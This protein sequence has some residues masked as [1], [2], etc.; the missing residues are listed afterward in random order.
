MG[1]GGFRALQN[2]LAGGLFK[3]L[4]AV[5]LFAVFLGAWAQPAVQRAA[6]G[7]ELS[8]PGRSSG[9]LDGGVYHSVALRADGTV[10]GWGF[11]V[12]GQVGDGTTTDRATPVQVVDLEEIRRVAAGGYHS[13]ALRSDETVWAWGHNGS[14][15]LGDGTTTNSSVPVAVSGL[16]GVQ[17]VAGGSHHSLALGSDGSL[18]AWGANGAGQLGD[19]T[20]EDSSSPVEVNDLSDVTAIAAGGLS[21]FAGHNLALSVDGTVW[22]WGHNNRGQLGDGSTTNRSSPV[23]VTG[24][25]D[26]VAVAADGA[27][28]YALKSDGTVW[29]WGDNSA[30]QLGNADAGRRST[31]PVRVAI[32]D[33]VAV[34][35]GG[36]HGL[37]IRSDG[38]AWAWGKNDEGQLGDGDGG[39]RNSTSAT[40]V[41]VRDLADVTVLAAG[42]AHSLAAVDDGSAWAWG[43]NSVGQLGDGTTTRRLTPV[44]IANLTGIRPPET[45]SIPPTVELT[46]PAIGVTVFHTTV[47]TA[48]ADDNV[49]VDRVELLIDG[50]MVASD[51]EEPYE[52]AWDTTE[53]SD[54]DRLV[55]VRA[56]DGAGLMATDGI[57]VIVANDATTQQ[58]L[59]SDFESGA[60]SVD[61]YVR[62]A[63]W[64]MTGNHDELPARY[65][66]ADTADEA[67]GWLF[68][69]LSHWESLSTGTQDELTAYLTL[70]EETEADTGEV[71]A[72]SSAWVDCGFSWL[73]F[74]FES[75]C[76]T[77]LSGFDLYY[78]VDGRYAVEPLE[79]DNGNGVPDVVDEVAQTLVA[80]KN[81][82]V[83]T[84]GFAD[85]DDTVDV[86]FSPTGGSA[87]S[88]PGGS[89][90]GTPG[91]VGSSILL[92]HD[93]VPREY[94]PAHEL[95]HQH[96]Y[97]YMTAF[98]AFANLESTL[99]WMEASAEWASRRYM[100][101]AGTP[102]DEKFLYSTSIDHFLGDPDNRLT[103][104]GNPQGGAPQYGAFLVAE[105]LD[106]TLG[107]DSVL[108]TWEEIDTGFFGADPDAR[109]A[110]DR[111]LQA[112][113]DST[114]EEELPI[115][116]ETA[117]FLDFAAS[118]GIDHVD[119][120]RNDPRA[121][122]GREATGGDTVISPQNRMAR[123]SDKRASGGEP[124]L[125]LSEGD[126]ALG[127]LS[128]SG[129]GA[130]VLEIQPDAPGELELV[131][132][133]DR[134][135]L[136]VAVLPLEEYGGAACGSA[137]VMGDGS[138]F[139]STVEFT[140]ACSYV[141]VLITNP[142]AHQGAVKVDYQVEFG[143]Q[144]DS[145]ITNGLLRLGIHPEGHLNVPGFD[146]SSGTGTTT[147]GLRYL[148]TNADALAPGCWCE[149]WGAA[150]TRSGVSGWANEDYGGASGLL[151]V[152]S[153]F[154]ATEGLSRVRVGGSSPVLEV[155][156]RYRPAPQTQNLYEIEVE[157]RNVTS[158]LA[159][160]LDRVHA[161]YR[162]VMDWDVEPTA[163]SE[164]VTIQPTSIV[165]PPTIAFTSNDGFAH[166]DPLR[167]PTDLGATGFFTDFGPMDQGALIDL[168]F[169][170]LDPGET[171]TFTM[172][173]GAAGNEDDALAALDAT[174][175]ELYSFGQPDT[176]DGATTGE[177]N[178][179]IWAYIGPASETAQ[180]STSEASGTT[181]EQGPSAG[182]GQNRNLAED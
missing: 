86:Y 97:Q 174:G 10:F 60:L 89:V 17:E 61:D 92:P 90:P 138:T 34:A 127:D 37:A 14:G 157:I 140:T 81:F 123:A 28:S 3:G 22:A 133:A 2:V 108:R 146:P 166:P 5:V 88:L 51:S 25:S 106:M 7:T 111:T 125:L 110:I 80:G 74:N 115:F 144:V 38:T 62:Y 120:W 112:L 79:D 57:G 153:D 50:V 78:T 93:I 155:S 158:V 85:L 1:F 177:P 55:E 16:E 84:L 132:H 99:W 147:V 109:K 156:H 15:T 65:G 175:A 176:D 179:F 95:F 46:A 35:A 18:W 43:A 128:V 11:N 67:S 42:H 9:V 129:G 23:Q 73:I 182:P 69:V 40:P 178:T 70:V 131:L 53:V 171:V 94:L 56:V 49:R 98:R 135:G 116:W 21:G 137:D 100:S 142:D 13:L 121:L 31:V 52:F 118:V 29:A 63:L 101:A 82:F 130:A 83:D 173:Y 77:S 76:K 48:T 145:T 64:S 12:Y 113:A 139:A 124:A 102:A 41:R 33:V 66:V 107:P 20:T 104:A 91:G 122:E 151:V 160:N 149:G 103:R 87:V 26:V 169:G 114:L 39:R 181:A 126:S 172:F 165:V 168:D 59:D 161:V 8:E 54:G 4:L 72:A 164:Y 134:S 44:Q 119:F 75:R 170:I 32:D 24:L 148:P 36:E 152:E 96:Q 71:S 6:G 30:D 143:E 141:A 163:F 180:T 136:D 159:G 117:Y 47:V 154:D 162:R 105:Y 45:D 27:N 68:G 167:Q 150:D 58:R 19:G